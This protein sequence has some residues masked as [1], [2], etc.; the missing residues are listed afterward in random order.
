MKIIK[1]YR[2][3]I[4][5]IELIFALVIIGIVLM[6][7][8]MLISQASQSNSVALQQEAIAAIATHTN[9]LLSKHWDEENAKLVG[10]VSPILHTDFNNSNFDFNLTETRRGLSLFNG[11]LTVHNNV[12]LNASS[13]G[14]DGAGDR[15]DIDDYHDQH[16]TVTVYGSQN[17]KSYEKMYKGD[18]IDINLDIHTKVKYIKDNQYLNSNLIGDLNTSNITIDIDPS[19]LIVGGLTSNIKFLNV[20]LS[21]T[22]GIKE[23]NKNITLQAFSCNI[24]TTTMNGKEYP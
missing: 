20:V 5:M 1:K 6:S 22:S 13:I 17:I 24:G 14:E 12:L 9:I 19:A 10:G 3:G 11:R 16:N 18:Y 7:A 23:L 21:S 2:Q 8:P 4:A 15:N